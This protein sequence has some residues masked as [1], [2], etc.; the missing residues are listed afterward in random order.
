MYPSAAPG[1]ITSTADLRKHNCFQ[2]YH[3]IYHRKQITQAALMHDLKMS[4]PTISQYLNELQSSGLIE[5]SGFASS[6]GGR[7]PSLFQII[8]DARISAGLEVV[9]SRVLLIITNLYGEVIF[10]KQ[11]M[12]EFSNTPS[13]FDTVCQWAN[14]R[15]R[16]TVSDDGRMLGIGIAVQGLPTVEGLTGGIRHLPGTLFRLEQL[17]SRLNYPCSWIHDVELAAKSEIWHNPQIENA[18]FLSLNRELGSALIINHSIHTGSGNFSSIIEHMCL[19]PGGR[20]CYCGKSGC[21]DAYCSSFALTQIAG[22]SLDTFFSKLRLGNK[23]EKKIW[24]KYLRD[25]AM[26]ID[27][28][29][30]II[31]NNILLGGEVETYMTEEDIRRLAA[32]VEEM[33]IIKANDL[34]ISRGFYGKNAAA[35]GG[36]LYYIEQ[37]LAQLPSQAE[38]AGRT[39]HL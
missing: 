5:K 1:L 11:L 30:M 4:A 27:N 34:T 3:H 38:A 25:L 33:T 18:F 10:K 17:S 16:Q 14:Q 23:S 31:R 39:N 8:P 12:I 22:E 35:I 32:Y 13:Y 29:R 6:S 2:V 24:E 19:Y 28:V 15:I 21:V 7:K 26:T 37:F 20:T 9:S 36:S